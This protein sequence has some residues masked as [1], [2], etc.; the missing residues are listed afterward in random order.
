MYDLDD[1]LQNGLNA[2]DQYVVRS[3]HDN[4]ENRFLASQHMADA[5]NCLIK[6][7]HETINP[8]LS[9]EERAKAAAYAEK[10]QNKIQA[11]MPAQGV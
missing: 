8:V 10:L 4:E 2:V 5:N 7:K 1:L 9:S 11:A 6:L 3:K